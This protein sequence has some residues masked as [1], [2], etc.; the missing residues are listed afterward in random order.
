MELH[1]WLFALIAYGIAVVIALCVTVIIKVIALTVRRGEKG[2][3][4]NAENDG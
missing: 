4:A 3:A 2:A 1:P